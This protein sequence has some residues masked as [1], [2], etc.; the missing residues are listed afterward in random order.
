[1]TKKRLPQSTSTAKKSKLPPYVREESITLADGSVTLAWYVRKQAWINGEKRNFRRSCGKNETSAKDVLQQ[2][3]RE[4]EKLR[5]PGSGNASTGESSTRTF[6]ELADYYEREKLKE[7]IFSGNVKVSGRKQVYTPRLYLGRQ[8]FDKWEKPKP[9]T[10]TSWRALIGNNTPLASITYERLVKFR[11]SLFTDYPVTKVIWKKNKEG[12]KVRH[13]RSQTRS[14][15]D[16][17]RRL[18]VLRSMFRIARL[19]F[20]PP[21][22]HKDPFKGTEA[23]IQI[24]LEPKRKRL[25]SEDEQDLLLAQCVGPRAHLRFVIL[26]LLDTCMRST[27]FFQLKVSDWERVKDEITVR[28]I[29]SKVA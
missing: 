15:C 18:E 6:G 21:W 26:G 2:I 1:M 12:K 9:I 28:Q 22:M 7:A 27:E 19:N 4:I 10:E 13:E 17:N 29:T 3:E 23:L 8:I 11:E 16:V 24:S 20:D 14:I 5:N 25:M